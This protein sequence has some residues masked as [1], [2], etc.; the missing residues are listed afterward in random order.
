MRSWMTSL[1]MLKA[2]T[3]LRDIVEYTLLVSSR[4]YVLRRLHCSKRTANGSVRRD[5]YTLQSTCVAIDIGYRP[6]WIV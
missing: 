3:R 4:A 2:L 5:G 6:T 1:D